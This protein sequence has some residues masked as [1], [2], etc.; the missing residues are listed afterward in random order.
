[1]ETTEMP[2]GSE[3]GECLSQTAVF[4]YI[5]AGIKQ[6]FCMTSWANLSS[7]ADSIDWAPENNRRRRLIS[8]ILRQCW[9]SPR[10]TADK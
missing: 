2:L 10:L 7:P 5:P 8:H 3:S 4:K 9:E 6:H 1:M